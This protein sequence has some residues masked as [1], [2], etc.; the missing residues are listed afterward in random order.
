VP[1]PPGHVGHAQVRGPSLFLGYARDGVT[2][3]PRLTPDGFFATGDL[4]A[5][6][7]DGTVAVRGREKDIIIRGGRNI[8]IA[9]VEG[10]VASHPAVEQACVVPVPD[11]LLG[12]RI[13]V[14]VVTELASF[15]VGTV[16]RHLAERG[17]TKGKWPEYVWRVPALPQNRVGKLSRTDAARIARELKDRPVATR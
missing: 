7:P 9:E 2:E 13:A 6:R 1:L 11:E 15:D 4:M 14:L 8:D 17:L 12:E 10:A 16:Q 3:P 5:V